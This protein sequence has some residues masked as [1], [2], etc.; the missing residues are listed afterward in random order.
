MP[1]GEETLGIRRFNPVDRQLHESIQDAVE[2]R[3]IGVRERRLSHSVMNPHPGGEVLFHRA[4]FD[5]LPKSRTRP[6][7]SVCSSSRL[8][9]ISR[10]RSY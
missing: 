10:T 5:D 4:R 8:G 9:F 1:V 6:P 7:L 2:D 3:L